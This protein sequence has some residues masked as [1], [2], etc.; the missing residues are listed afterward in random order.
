MWRWVH[1][2]GADVLEERIDLFERGAHARDATAQP[3]RLR[4]GAERR[5]KCRIRSLRGREREGRLAPAVAHEGRGAGDEQL[6]VRVGPIMERRE[7]ERVVAVRAHTAFRA[8]RLAYELATV[9]G[10]LAAA[11]PDCV[12]CMQ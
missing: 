2:D 10:A 1:V 11:R 8:K 5:A 3:H 12:L 4:D 6:R 7:V 9:L